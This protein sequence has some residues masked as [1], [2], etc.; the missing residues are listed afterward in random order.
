MGKLVP[1]HKKVKIYGMLVCGHIKSKHKLE[2]YGN[3]SF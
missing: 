1:K 2:I 3:A